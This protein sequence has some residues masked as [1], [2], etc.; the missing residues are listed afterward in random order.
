MPDIN[1][2]QDTDKPDEGRGKKQKKD[3]AEGLGRAV[4]MHRP[5]GEKERSRS[6]E[7]TGEPKRS[8]VERAR[9]FFRGSQQPKVLSSRVQDTD[10][11]AEKS[12]G[13][14]RTPVDLKMDTPEVKRPP[15]AQP[16]KTPEDNKTHVSRWSGFMNR[17][18]TRDARPPKRTPSSASP[19]QQKHPATPMQPA[20]HPEPDTARA[21]D[22]KRPQEPKQQKDKP[23]KSNKVDDKQPDI[24]SILGVNLMPEEELSQVEQPQGE[25]IAI[26][27]WA[28]GAVVLTA[29]VHVGLILYH[30]NLTSKTEEVQRD[31]AQLEQEISTFQEVKQQSQQLGQETERVSALLDRHI[32]W[33]E[34]FSLLEEYT[35]DEVTYS[36]IDGN[37]T[38]TLT[39]NAAGRDYET[40][41]RQILA[42]RDASDFVQEATILS[43]TTPVSEST[44]GTGVEILRGDSAFSVRLVLSPNVFFRTGTQVDAPPDE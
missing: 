19:E 24:P 17:I 38:G 31:V 25:L 23:S 4:Q 6:S 33:T 2:L 7:T 41:A 21:A 15:A 29:I 27:L 39:L 32:Y 35:V 10:Q 43:A 1:L 28:A 16:A 8:F 34:F 5:E 9:H 30:G 13:E 37:I 26:G 11:P 20:A 42:F 18:T 44:S 22:P 3:R 36:G 14:Q 12:G 40:V